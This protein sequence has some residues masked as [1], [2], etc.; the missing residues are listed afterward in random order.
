[1]FWTYN[2]DDSSDQQEDNQQGKAPKMLIRCVNEF[3]EVGEN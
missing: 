2:E 3:S 1:M